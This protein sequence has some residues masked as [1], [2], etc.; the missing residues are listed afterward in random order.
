MPVGTRLSVWPRTRVVHLSR[1][2]RYI[3]L[4]DALPKCPDCGEQKLVLMTAQL[5]TCQGCGRAYQ[6]DNDHA[7][8]HNQDNTP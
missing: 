2:C 5:I 8:H 4:V 1:S 6:K 7:K 3:E